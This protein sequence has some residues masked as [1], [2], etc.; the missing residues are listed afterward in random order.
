V[1]GVGCLLVIPLVRI[2][3][4]KARAARRREATKGKEPAQHRTTHPM[5]LL[6]LSI[7]SVAYATMSPV[8][9]NDQLDQD[10]LIRAQIEI[11]TMPKY[12]RPETFDEKLYRKVRQA[13]PYA[14]N[15]IKSVPDS[16]ISLM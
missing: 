10:A 3:P 1:G 2:L 12:T 6:L 14:L 9:E 8:P 5:L 15:C 11:H 7:L 16:P 4:D 13:S